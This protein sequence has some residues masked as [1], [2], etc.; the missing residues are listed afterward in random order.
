VKSAQLVCL[1]ADAENLLQQTEH[2]LGLV[3]L[4]ELLSLANRPIV[5][6][7]ASRRFFELHLGHL[8]YV[9]TRNHWILILLKSALE[10]N[11]LKL[12]VHDYWDLSVWQYCDLV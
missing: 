9:Y 4:G 1:L 8:I 11:E 2:H 6:R 12:G 7:D 10:C 5:V 3:L